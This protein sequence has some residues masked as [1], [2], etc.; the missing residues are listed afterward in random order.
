MLKCFKA[1]KFKSRAQKGLK[2][3]AFLKSKQIKSL[4]KQ[5]NLIDSNKTRVLFTIVLFVKLTR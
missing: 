2:T 1:L 4:G 3:E 5:H